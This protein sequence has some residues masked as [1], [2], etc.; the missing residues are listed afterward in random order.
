ML[1]QYADGEKRYHISPQGMKFGDDVIT[2]PKAKAK[3]GNRMMLKNIPV[4]F[5]IHNVE[6]TL[7]RGGQTA[8]SAGGVAKLVSLEG[9]FAQVQ[10]PSKEVRFVHKECYASI[11]TVGNLDH[12]NVNL[13]K[14]GRAR[15]KGLRPEVRGKAKNPVDHP[16]GGGEGCTPIG[17]KHPKTPWGMPALGFKTRRRKNP[18]SKW[19]VRTRKGKQLVKID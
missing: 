4:G 7:G 17:L 8:R 18:T 14:A 6:L 5:E 11:G 16:H 15:W 1:V 13:G 19:I 10:L 2:K 12:Q 9:R 3:L